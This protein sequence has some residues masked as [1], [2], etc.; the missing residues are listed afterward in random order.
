VVMRF[1]P[2]FQ[3]FDVHCVISVLRYARLRVALFL[4][5]GRKVRPH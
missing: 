2:D 3:F 4:L 5:I 1:R